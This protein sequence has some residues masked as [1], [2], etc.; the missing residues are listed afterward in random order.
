MKR[1]S[2]VEMDFSGYQLN[3]ENVSKMADVEKLYGHKLSV[4]IRQID[5][6]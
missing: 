5:K 3:Y 1:T 4:K 6:K 2:L